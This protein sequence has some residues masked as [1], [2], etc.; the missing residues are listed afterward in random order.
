MN[1]LPVL[2]GGLGLWQAS[3]QNRRQNNTQ[4]QANDLANQGMALAKD[5][6]DRFEAPTMERLLG[7]ANNYDPGKEAQGA[8]D[9]ASNTAS[10]AIGRALRQYDT[11]YRAGGGVP[12]QTSM[13]AAKQQGVMKPI[14]NDLAQTVANIQMNS[15]LKKADLLRSILSQSGPGSL[16]DTYFANSNRLSSMA[17]NMSGGNFGAG[18]QMLGQGLEG[19]FKNFK[20]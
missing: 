7:L 4:N 15:T 10:E 3:E 16:A 8:V 19:L 9:T 20:W 6:Y 13:Y 18:A 17:N 12:G 5:R 11:R 2:M 1:V 14:A